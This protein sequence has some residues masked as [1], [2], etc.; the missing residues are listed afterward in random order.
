MSVC[1]LKV[2]LTDNETFEKQ[3]IMPAGNAERE[4]E[5]VT[6]FCPRVG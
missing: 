3:K 5:C 4:G 6:H 2:Q 1:W